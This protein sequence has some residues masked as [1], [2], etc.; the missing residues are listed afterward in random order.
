MLKHD[1]KP[2]Q[3]CQFL[4]GYFIFSKPESLNKELT[5][6]IREQLRQ[7]FKNEI[8]PSYPKNEQQ[9]L[10]EIHNPQT[11]RHGGLELMC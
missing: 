7:T 2:N 6:S 11:K 5:S 4:N 9:K 10:N 8:D 3:F 1:P